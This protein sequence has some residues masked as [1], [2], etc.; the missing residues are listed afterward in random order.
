VTADKQSEILY[1]RHYLLAHSFSIAVVAI[2]MLYPEMAFAQADLADLS[3]KS[4][5]AVSWIKTAVHAILVVSVIGSG[6]MA[7]FGR[8]SWS[9]VGQVIIGAVV[10]GLATEVVDALYG[11]GA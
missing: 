8:M 9:T 2:I 11:A 7:A 10:A 1:C 5:D 3:S 6:V 4:N